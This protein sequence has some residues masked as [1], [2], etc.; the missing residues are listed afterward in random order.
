MRDQED[1]DFDAALGIG[2]ELAIEDLRQ[3]LKNP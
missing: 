1:I 2:E 3:V